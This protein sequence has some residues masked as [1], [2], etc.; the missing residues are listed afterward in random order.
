MSQVRLKVF[1]LCGLTE[2]FLDTV[3]PGLLTTDLN[4][5]PNSLG[6]LLFDNVLASFSL[7]TRYRNN[8][9]SFKISVLVL[10]LDTNF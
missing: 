6:K 7:Y 1:S 3:N 9:E 4:P 5:H 2:Y 8:N 10:G